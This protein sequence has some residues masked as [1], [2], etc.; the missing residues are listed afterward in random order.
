MQNLSTDLNCVHALHF[1]AERMKNTVTRAFCDGGLSLSVWVGWHFLRKM[2]PLPFSMEPGF[3]KHISISLKST[4]RLRQPD[5]LETI[6]TERHVSCKAALGHGHTHWAQLFV[7]LN[8]SASCASS[9]L[10]W[11]L[12]ILQ[13]GDVEWLLMEKIR[14]N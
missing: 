14:K 13:G 1:T 12:L 8:E 6:K 4:L 11:W 10:I 5:N 9:Q 7:S 2:T 3:H